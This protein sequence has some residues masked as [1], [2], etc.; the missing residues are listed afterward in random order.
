MSYQTI[1]LIAP[2]ALRTRSGQHRMVRQAVLGD[3]WL[4][5]DLLCR[6]SDRTRQLRYM[7]SRRPSAELVWEEA[8]RM[9]RGITRDHVTLIASVHVQGRE[10]A[11]AVAEWVRDRQNPTAGEIAI[12][13]SDDEQRQGIGA[14]LMRQLVQSAQQGGLTQLRA[15]MMAEN[16]AMLRLLRGLGLPL[17][18]STSYGETQAIVR[19]RPSAES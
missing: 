3:V 9:A 15:D 12:V 7:T 14:T 13:V 16:Q 19:L 8:S 6:I 11:V 1:P 5:V 17:A 10:R 18:I 2:L 4:L